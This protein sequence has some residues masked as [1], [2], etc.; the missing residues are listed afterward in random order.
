[1]KILA[2]NCR[3]LGK[4]SA[5]RALKHLILTHHP[6]LIF[7]SETKL[8]RAEFESKINTFGNRLPHKFC[9]DCTVSSNSRRGGLAMIW[10]SN[11][12]LSVISSNERMIDCYVDCGNMNDSWRATGIY[13][14]SIHNQ[15]PRTCDLIS[16]LANT[17]QHENWL[18]FGDFNMI[19]NSNEK[20]GGRH[21]HDNMA[22]LFHNTL[23]SCS[24]T[25]LGFQG[26]I[27]T[28]TNNQEG[29]DHIKERLDRYCASTNWITKFP[30]FTNY[31][32]LNSTSDHNP[33]LLVFGTN[34]DFRNDSHSKM[35][36]KRFENIWVQDT[37]CSQIIKDTWDQ[38][39][40]ET[41]QKLQQVMDNLANWGKTNYGSIPKDIKS[42]QATL[43]DLK[44]QTP[45][46]ETIN[47]IQQMESKLDG[48]LLKEEQWWAQR[49][50]TN[51]LQ[52]GDKNSKFFHFK[53][54][55]RHRKNKI[56]FIKRP[57]GTISTHNTDIQEGFQQYFTTLFTSTNPTN[58]QET[59][60]VVANRVTP[61]MKVYL[62]QDFIAA[63]VSYATH[64]LK[65][66][67]AP[68]PDGL[69][70]N[71]FQIYWDTIGGEITQ[72]V[73]N[74]LNNGGNPD[75]YNDTFICLIPKH[76]NPT[77]PVDYRPIALCNVMLKI[78]TKTIANRIKTILPEVISPQQSAFLPGR[79]IS[80]NTL[81]AFETFQ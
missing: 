78:I 21:N 23:N 43:Q 40:G 76:K 7:L 1:M 31:H 25:D 55:Q 71:F 69:N 41:H 39:R 49:A 63:E 38:S 45:S 56:N 35:R 28:W 64:Q 4:P 12:N 60:N 16:E 13:G 75:S 52:H 24:L 59:I 17:N 14:Y 32:L 11:V 51:W 62:N 10:T 80:D 42:T 44:S 70:A 67:A 36:T 47:I 5:V 6:D 48:L 29:T 57:D 50:R 20:Y 72:T 58:M 66:N 81:I 15:K 30:R 34:L 61:Q 9:V 68:G 22:S 3:G 2:W 65:S 18:L 46:R 19:L 74:I 73:L 79:L 53:A 8:Q 33:I 77:S 37:N 27:F 54:S 26:D